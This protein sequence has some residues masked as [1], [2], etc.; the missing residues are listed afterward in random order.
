MICMHGE[1]TRAILEALVQGPM[2]VTAIVRE[3]RMP[4]E[5]VRK[6][7][8]R[9]SKEPR[10]S[11][12]LHIVRWDDKQAHERACPRPVFKLGP[13]SNCRRPAP[14]PRKELVR[15]YYQKAQIE[16]G[17]NAFGPL[18]PQKVAAKLVSKHRATQRP[19]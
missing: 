2:G 17:V 16:A 9:M 4:R 14:K 3:T 15:R 10:V 12:R 19:T 6:A 7:C 5:A 13:G 8:D 11:R 18:Y 1:V